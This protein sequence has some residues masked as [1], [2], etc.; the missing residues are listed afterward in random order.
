MSGVT[1]RK[2][3]H[4]DLCAHQDVETDRGT[5]LDDV[6]LIH[7][8]LPEMSAGD[9]DASTDLFGRRL[10]APILISGMTGGTGR[11]GEINLTL[12]TAAQK[13]GLGMGLGSQRAMW[14]DP[15][16]A[17]TYRVRGVAPD[18][19]LLANLG[20][21]QAREVGVA[22]V[23]EL[24]DSVGA[25][26]LCVHLNVAQ[27]MV[28]DEGDRDFRGCL[29]TIESLAGSLGFPIIIKETGCGFSRSTLAR[30]RS[31]GADWVDVAGTGGTTWT[32]VE[33]LRG[34]NR[35]RALGVALREWGVPT[36]AALY[37]ARETGLE[38]I[39]SGGIRGPLDI[40]RSLVLGANA[41]GLALPFLRAH[42]AKGLDGV[43]SLGEHLSEGVRALM[44]LLGA[45]SL[46][47][48]RSS[49]FV[50]GPQLQNWIQPPTHFADPRR[51]V[52]PHA[53]DTG[54]E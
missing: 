28:Q 36:A 6:Q 38:A 39:A 31:A 1:Q 24:V 30:L 15:K 47:S 5:L 19:L 32:G 35:Q 2:V 14:I 9:V 3:E 54:S 11:A 29:A 7:E 18:I 21:V 25:D 44:L 48:L 20:V 46:D 43:L 34:S 49:A 26:A 40:V 23:T 42:E 16:L 52:M 10:Q 22:A 37:Y 13:L 17:S 50:M 53:A 12:A 51:T 41:V 45:D 4:L 8:A 27:E 33:A